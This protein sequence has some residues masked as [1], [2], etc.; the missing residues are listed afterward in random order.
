MHDINFEKL[1][2]RAIAIYTQERAALLDGN[3]EALQTAERLKSELL[4]DLQMAEKA[5]GMTAASPMA[6]ENQAQL[7]SL[8]S[9]I[10]RRTT[11][12]NVLAKANN[13]E[14]RSDQTH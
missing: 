6:V 9:I 1:T 12:N 7:K 4:N 3:A 10:E 8:H 14:L 2:K 13:P 5:V 11:E